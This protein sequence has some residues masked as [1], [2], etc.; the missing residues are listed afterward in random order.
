MIIAVLPEEVSQRWNEFLIVQQRFEN[1]VDDCHE[2]NSHARHAPQ[3]EI[4]VRW[5][6]CMH[7]AA[8]LSEST[9]YP[10]T[11]QQAQERQV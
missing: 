9:H 2:R 1:V 11:Q 4:V 3:P 6:E 7:P 8:A 10:A 5:A